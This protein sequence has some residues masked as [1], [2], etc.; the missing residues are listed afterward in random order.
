MHKN[1]INR[2]HTLQNQDTKKPTNCY[3]HLSLDEREIIALRLKSNISRRAIAE[4]L[5][6]ETSTI[7]REI[8]RNKDLRNDEYRAT[9]AQKKT[10]TRKIDVYKTERLKNNEIRKIVEEKLNDG[11]SPEQIAGRLKLEHGQT[12]T[13]HESI[14][15]WIYQERNDLQPLLVRATKKRRKRS[16]NNKKRANRIP[17]RTPI[18]QRP[19]VI[20]NREEAGHWEAD[21]VVSRL[22]KS[23]LSVLTERKHKI[24]LISKIPQK[25]AINMKDSLINRLREYPQKLRQSI[26]Y[27]NGLENALHEKV[28]DEINTSSYFCNA[29]HSWEK[30]T[31]ENSIGLIRQYLPKKTDFK[32]IDKNEIEAIEYALNNRPKKC[33]GYLTPIESLSRD[34]AL[35]H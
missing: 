6:R 24:T 13:N 16:N 12:V 18:D 9:L 30:G 25:T 4:E 27:D 14:Y 19:A 3:S 2:R 33:L 34:V 35:G 31:V 11:W 22:S 21:T 5:Q 20:E 32:T 10:E 23:A 17:N 1:R 7:C 26:T 29:Y 8:N 28:N 15:L